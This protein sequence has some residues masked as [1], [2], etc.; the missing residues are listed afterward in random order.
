MPSATVTL[1]AASVLSELSA[2]YGLLSG[3]HLAVLMMVTGASEMVA[4]ELMVTQSVVAAAAEFVVMPI[5]GQLSDSRGRRPVLMFSALGNTLLRALVA[6]NPCAATI[7]GAKLGDALT[8]SFDGT[9]GSVRPPSPAGDPP[10]TRR[11]RRAACR[12][13]GL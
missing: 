9:V 2:Q 12:W 13:P 6:A 10:F 11:R 5:A 8:R 3:A 4:G 7:W 1:T